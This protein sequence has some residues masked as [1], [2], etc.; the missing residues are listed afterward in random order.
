MYK[1]KIFKD[2]KVEQEWE[3]EL[4]EDYEV[5]KDKWERIAQ[6]TRG[7]FWA[8]ANRTLTLKAN[9]VV[10]RLVVDYV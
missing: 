6:Q 5:I 7:K 9:N 3:S 8:G 2:Q 4:W 10:R 1:F